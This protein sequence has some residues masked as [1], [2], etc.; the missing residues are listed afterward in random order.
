MELRTEHLPRISRLPVH[1][2]NV[3]NSCLL[4]TLPHGAA[5]NKK[6][7]SFS[8]RA[9]SKVSGTLLPLGCRHM[10]GLSD[11]WNNRA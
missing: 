4:G 7:T 5:W 9:R 11:W 10:V 8:C 3:I 2:E 1:T 6:L